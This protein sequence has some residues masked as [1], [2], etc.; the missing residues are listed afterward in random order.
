[1]IRPHERLGYAVN[2]VHIAAEQIKAG[3]VGQSSEFRVQSSE[4]R[5]QSS[6]LE[7]VAG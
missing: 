5:V 3:F 7:V 2:A 6:E 1:L 4:F